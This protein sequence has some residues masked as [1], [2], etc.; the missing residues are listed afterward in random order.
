MELDLDP[1]A[2][3]LLADL[4][5]DAIVALGHRGVTV[6]LGGVQRLP[7]TPSQKSS[8]EL[9]LPCRNW[10]LGAVEYGGRALATLSTYCEVGRG[11]GLSAP[12]LDPRNGQVVSTA[13]GD[14]SGGCA[15]WVL[16][17]T[18]EEA[19]VWALTLAILGPNEGGQLLA[20]QA[21]VEWGYA[22]VGPTVTDRPG[23]EAVLE[24]RH[25][26]GFVLTGPARA[27]DSLLEPTAP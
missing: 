4:A 16:A 2:E 11:P 13:S 22:R 5:L 6:E 18:G 27:A 26:P 19:R 7:N 15:C 21:N 23:S 14:E 25:S 12:M 17:P 24:W 3:G 10:V 8:T 20:G 9:L 1:V